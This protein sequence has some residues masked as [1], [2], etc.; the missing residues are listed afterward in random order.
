MRIHVADAVRRL[1]LILTASLIALFPGIEWGVEAAVQPGQPEGRIAFIRDGDVWMWTSNGT[2]AL[3]SPGDAQDPAWSPDGTQLLFVENGGS[4]SN[5][6]LHDLADDRTIRLTDNEAYVQS[7]S[8]DYVASS[9][10][11]IDPSWSGS[12]EIA[13]IS[14]RDASDDLMQ[15][16][17]LDSTEEEPYLAMYDGGDAGSIEH[18]TINADADFVAYT[19]LASGGQQG[20]ITYVAIR[21]LQ[22]GTTT[23]ITEGPKGAYDPAIAPDGETM[24]VSIR[25]EQGMSDLWL[26]DV[27]SG[28]ATRL[29]AKK[30][31]A[32]PE[33]SPDGSWIAFT[34]PND[35]SFDIWAAPIDTASSEL[36]R[37]PVRIVRESGVD[38]TSGLSWTGAAD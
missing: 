37:D 4:Y 12:G 22:D 7:G 2:T 26:V 27:S 25:D 18:V 1:I 16:W 8:P 28:E 9:S 6:V 35:R 30:Q 10:W 3:T 11:A 38:A 36:T 34:T 15:L 21:D 13:F 5:L 29:T 33:W 19:V 31:A 24:V 32:N 14:D 20:G 23:P 17:L